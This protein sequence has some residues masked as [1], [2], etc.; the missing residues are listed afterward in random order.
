VKFEES[1]R[2]GL[3]GDHDSVDHEG[4]VF[5]VLLPD[6]AKIKYN[7]QESVHQIIDWGLPVH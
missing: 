2:V 6:T 7:N 4:A 1:A 5:S 3:A